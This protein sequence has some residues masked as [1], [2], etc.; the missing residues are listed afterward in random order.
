[1]TP[2]ST[3][4][5]NL[6]TALSSSK[7]LE[8]IES[9]QEIEQF[10]Q[11]TSSTKEKC[12]KTPTR[13]GDK[14]NYSVGAS[15]SSPKA[16]VVKENIPEV[17]PKSSTE[18]FRPPSEATE[19]NYEKE[20]DVTPCSISH[21]KCNELPAPDT[22]KIFAPF[23]EPPIPIEVAQSK[24]SQEKLKKVPTPSETDGS[25]DKCISTPCT[26]EIQVTKSPESIEKVSEKVDVI[27]PVIEDEDNDIRTKVVV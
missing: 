20:K 18:I 25:N 8:S 19:S 17:L 6:S 12:D 9:I 7:S 24:K 4:S 22:P 26:D 14:E 1:M 11:E 16:D 5:N 3:P 13:S 23:T 2:P 21:P 15:L 10:L 27:T